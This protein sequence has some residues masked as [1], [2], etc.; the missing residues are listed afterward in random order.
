MAP[1]APTAAGSNRRA[2]RL[3]RLLHLSIAHAL[4]GLFLS[5]WLLRIHAFSE[6]AEAPGCGLGPATDCYR[7]AR[8][9]Y[10]ELFGWPLAAYAGLFFLG[11]LAL[12]LAARREPQ[13]LAPALALQTLL[14][15]LGLLEGL[16]LIAIQAWVIEAW[17]LL[18]LALDAVLLALVT[19]GAAPW[20]GRPRLILA[21]WHLALGWTAR[22]RRGRLIGAA[23]VLSLAA[24]VG[25]GITLRRERLLRQAQQ[26]LV[27]RPVEVPWLHNGPSRGPHDAR[28]TIVMFSDFQCGACARAAEVL[29]QL[30]EEQPDLRLVHQDFPLDSLC[31]PLMDRRMHPLACWAA[32][33]ADCAGSQGSY[34]EFHDRLFMRQQRL[35]E[36]EL[37]SLVIELNLDLARF[38]TC[39][40]DSAVHS[41]FSQR[42]GR[43]LQLQ[44]QRTPT[45]FINGYRVEGNPGLDLLR[46]IVALARQR[47]RGSQ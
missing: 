13:R 33:F 44:I 8:T 46:Q 40:N 14:A 41:Q 39:V 18:C 45:L 36:A 9:E 28:V 1:R 20:P 19:A 6:Y 26:A 11:L 17:C 35:S 25:S 37:K 2:R 5:V 22:T 24:L 34:W 12:L 27:G 4:L 21:H 7:V 43:A 30:I 10:S 3:R 47:A 15:G 16:Y 42:I 38:Q 29:D 31:N 32:L 23:L